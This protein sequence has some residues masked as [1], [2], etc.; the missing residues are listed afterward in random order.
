MGIFFSLL[1]AHAW[2]MQKKKICKENSKAKRIKI[3]LNMVASVFLGDVRVIG[4]T[5]KVIV[6]IKELWSCVSYFDFLIFKIVITW[7][8]YAIL[9]CFHTQHANSLLL[10]IHVQVYCDL[11]ITRDTCVN[12]YWLN[13]LDLFLKYKIS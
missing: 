12:V 3:L 8:T 1:Y 10:L 2:Y 6:S 11:T 7:D 13:C 4:C 5:L 9:W